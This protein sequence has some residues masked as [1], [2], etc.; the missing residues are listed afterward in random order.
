MILVTNIDQFSGLLFGLI[1][2][3]VLR[4]FID[5]IDL[6]DQLVDP[7]TVSGHVGAVSGLAL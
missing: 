5:H 3:I 7:C 1:Q 2:F 6:R 4:Q